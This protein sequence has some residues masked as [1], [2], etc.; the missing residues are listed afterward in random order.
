MSLQVLAWGISVAGWIMSP[1][2]SK[3]LD[4]AWS[5]YKC[6]KQNTI[7]NLLRNILPRL[8]YTLEAIE[9]MGK[10]EIFEEMVRGLK[11]AFYDIEDILDELGYIRHQ[12]HADAETKSD[13]KKK[14][15]I[16]VEAEAGPSNQDIIIEVMALTEALN[17]RLKDSMHKIEILLD[18]AQSIIPLAVLVDKSKEGEVSRKH[19]TA[20]NSNSSNPRVNVTGRDEDCSRIAQILRDPSSS[21]SKCFSVIG[22][23]GISGSGKTTLAQHVCKYEENEKYF[24]LVMWIHVSQNYSAHDIFKEMFEAAS[25]DNY[26]CLDVLEEEL[27]K[28]LDGKRFLLVLDDIWCN[29]DDDEHKL[30]NLLSPLNLGK[31]GSKIL[32]TS[33]NKE[34]F[35]YLCPGVACIDFEI[36]FLDDQTFLE[37]FMHYALEC[38][39]PNGLDQ[40]ELRSI[41]AEIAQKLKGS[42]LAACMVGG[43]LRKKQNNIDLWRMA[44]DCDL[45]NETTGFVWWSYQQ[46]DEHV[47]RCFS[48]CSIFPR[49]H[50][51][52]RDDLVKLWVA[53]GFIESNNPE[54]DL[55]VV[56]QRYF[57]ELLAASFI[58]ESKYG[59][60]LFYLVHDL[61]YDL[62]EKVA[63][64]DCFT[65]EN[66]QRRQVPPDVRHLFVANGEM[67]TEDIFE[68]KNLRTLI[69][70]DVGPSFLANEVFFEK[71]FQKLLKLR[72]LA[73]EYTHTVTSGTRVLEIPQTIGHLKHLRHLA[74]ALP[75]GY[76]LILPRALTKLY[77]LRVL[78]FQGNHDLEFPHD[79]DMGKL[80]NLRHINTW[81]PR[82]PQLTL[83]NIAR[84]TSLRTL[85]YFILGTKPGYEIK[86]LRNL[87]KLQGHLEIQDLKLVK[88][89]NEALE[90]NLVAKTRLTG[91]TLFWYINLSSKEVQAEVLEGLCPPKGLTDLKIVGYQGPGYPSW[92]VG[93]Q[94]N[95]P[96]YLNTLS[97]AS[98]FWMEP[99]PE[100]FECFIH[101]H[102]FTIIHMNWVYLP[103]NVK[104]LRWLK[105]LNIRDCWN[106]ISLQ[107]LPRSLENF[108]LVCRDGDFAESCKQVDHPNWQK[109]QHVKNCSIRR[110]RGF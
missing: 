110:G 91:L 50:R 52:D 21:D 45:L 7:S 88:S 11:S 54:E 17:S 8:V 34:S 76:K 27:E 6:D 12:Q 38:T 47:R 33:R 69:I 89:K 81:Y 10:R 57:D 60:K 68:L 24:D 67:V 70:Y 29:E 4:K 42:P 40:M 109:L 32:A 107:E 53:E 28:K 19:V 59:G 78:N 36:K 101:L 86:Q 100:L 90:A 97:L 103:D 37:L 20:T 92:M 23:Y 84:L 72:V 66:G 74:L 9:A 48:Y 87:N 62:A 98:C 64:N 22:I 49:K 15:K 58:Q 104:D 94:N 14:G 26:N 63:G 102:E 79:I 3:L 83:P 41:G 75:Y 16:N 80:S 96:K 85:Q 13:K 1:I 31:K 65:I 105:S 46:L 99:A 43:Q 95:G 35:S 106:M 44:L 18:E 55:E 71:V 51:L 25:M 56:G 61:M 5:Y 2:I 93:L 73:I 39:S 77:H 108:T 82:I 30:E